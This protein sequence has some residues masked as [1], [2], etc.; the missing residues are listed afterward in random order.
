[1]IMVTPEFWIRNATV[2]T[3]R[4]SLPADV[5]VRGEKIIELVRRD[6]R[7]G[8]AAGRPSARERAPGGPHLP[9]L[10]AGT[11][12]PEA[13]EA[14]GLWLLPG[15]VDAHVH[16]GM[17]PRPGITSLGWR[18]SSEAALLGGTTTIIDFA[19]PRGDE[20]LAA[21][22]DRRRAEA[23]GECLCDFGLHVTVTPAAAGRLAELPA[24]VERGCPSFK[25]FL[26][27]P[28]RLMLDETALRRL[29]AAAAAAGGQVLIHAE[30]GRLVADRQES[31]IRAGRTGPQWHSAAH[32]PEAEL[33]AV[34]QTLGLAVATRCP[35]LLVHLTLAGS[36]AHLR[37]ARARAARPG[38]LRGE[39][40]LHHLVA[41][42]GCCRD[43]DEDHLRAVFSPPL[44]SA[45]DS[46]ALLAGLA[47]GSLDLLSTDHCEFTLRAKRKAA[48]D[49]FAAIPNGT[50]GVGERLALSHDRA[51]RTGDMRRERWVMVCCERPAALGGLA[52][53][54][55]CIAPGFDADLVLFDPAAAGPWQPLGASDPEASLYTGLPVQGRVRSVWLRGRQVVREG[56]LVRPAAAGQFL[57]RS[58]VDW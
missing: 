2:I 6:P 47:D 17:S 55:G 14:A 50:G 57:V 7:P 3:G 32:P 54:K 51:V 37:R 34:E 46:A 12:P 5:H 1:M 20:P 48:S 8:T 58:P 25:A 56:G 10:P 39:V 35:L 24:L 21:A 23:A 31:L 41:S 15:G 36:L 40:C 53:R 45:Q 52:G 43:T 13:V 38:H 42:S 18:Q 19:E 30:D 27:Y 44:R 9:P 4:Q 28:D 29:M 33:R 49:G 26:A 11:A 22:V 16:C